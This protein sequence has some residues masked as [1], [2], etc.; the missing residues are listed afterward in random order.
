MAGRGLSEHQRQRLMAEMVRKGAQ[1]PGIA[2]CEQSD[3][4]RFWPGA[5]GEFCRFL[6]S[7]PLAAMT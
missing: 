6:K 2:V 5:I 7:A 1:L 4:A 3:A